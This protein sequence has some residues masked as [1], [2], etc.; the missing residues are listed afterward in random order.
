MIGQS[1]VHPELAPT[2]TLPRRERGTSIGP[3][4]AAQGN[5]FL[6]SGVPLTR[7]SR[8][9]GNL[10]GFATGMSA[11]AE[12]PWIPA[13]AGMT[14]SGKADSIKTRLPW[15]I[16]GPCF[17]GQW[18]FA[19]FVFA[20]SFWARGSATV[21]VGRSSSGPGHRPLKAEIRGSNP[22]RPTNLPIFPLTQG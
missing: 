22:L 9:S 17:T 3:S 8:E 20:E 15:P 6:N 4:P 2:L 1:S 16:A 12:S 11:P 14:G 21:L 7:H 18:T 5:R 19:I 10:S 13:F